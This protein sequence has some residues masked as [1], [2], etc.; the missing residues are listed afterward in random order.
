LRVPFRWH[1]SLGCWPWSVRRSPRSN[2]GHTTN[3]GC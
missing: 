2:S 3:E 1:S